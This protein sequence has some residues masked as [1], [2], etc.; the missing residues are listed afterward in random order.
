MPTRLMSRMREALPS[1]MLIVM[2]T[3]LRS[4]SVTEG[5]IATLYLPR[6]LYWRIS[7][8]V[9]RSRFSGLK[10]SPSARP[11]PRRPLSRSSVS[12]SLLPLSLSVL[13][14]GRSV[15]VTTRMSPWRSSLTS[16]KKPVRNR[17]RIASAELPRSSVSPFSTGR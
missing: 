9:T 4:R 1:A 13:M 14:A 15:T 2:S 7:S 16:L 17:A 3:R 6:L 10:V 12:M 5:V 11:M 8:W